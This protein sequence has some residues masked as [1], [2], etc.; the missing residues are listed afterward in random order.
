MSAFHIEVAGGTTVRL[1]TAGKYCDR[2]IT[3]TATG[4]GITDRGVAVRS[5][6]EA[7]M[8]GITEAFLEAGKQYYL[9][10]VKFTARDQGSYVAPPDGTVVDNGG[11]YST[12]TWDGSS[13]GVYG[14]DRAP[15]DEHGVT[16]YRVVGETYSA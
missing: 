12:V 8:M 3:V 4:G 7:D 14:W 10:D 5:F 16:F 15:S 11:N 13:W 9:E 2:D 1:P 6:A